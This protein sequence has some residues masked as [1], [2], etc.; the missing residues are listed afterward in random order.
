M[1]HYWINHNSGREK[2]VPVSCET[3]TIMCSHK[4]L[5]TADKRTA[6]DTQLLAAIA[7]GRVES[8]MGRHAAALRI[9]RGAVGRAQRVGIVTVAF[10][11]RL[12]LGGAELAAGQE[13]RGRATLRALEREATRRGF[14]LI[15]RNAGRLLRGFEGVDVV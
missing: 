7:V 1:V 12:A 5:A 10:E 15:A 14:K 6:I 3:T 13:A 11:G 4:A 9:L 8:S 2:V